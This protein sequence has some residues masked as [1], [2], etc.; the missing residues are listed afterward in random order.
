MTKRKKIIIG[1]AGT[2]VILLVA[3]FLLLPTLINLDLLREKILAK[4]SETE[5]VDIDFEKLELDFFPRPY[6]AVRQATVSIPGKAEGTLESLTVYPQILPLLR[7]KFRVSELV[8]AAPDFKV[9]LPER[10]KKEKEEE[11][12]SP[13]PWKALKEKVTS[14]LGHLTLKAAGL[15]VMVRNGRLELLD[16][17]K[18]VLKLEDIGASVSIPLGE[19]EADITCS[20]TCC[21]KVSIQTQIDMDDLE[22][23]GQIHLKHFNPNMIPAELIPPKV[24]RFGDSRVNL[25]VE[26]ETEGL[27]FIKGAVKGSTPELTV[28]NKN[29]K[30]VI[31]GKS[32]KGTFYTDAEK[33]TISVSELNLDHPRLK[34]KGEFL[35]DRNRAKPELT[36]NIQ[37]KD[38]DVSSG[39]IA[40]LVFAERHSVCR[41]ICEVLQGGTVQQVTFGIRGSTKQ[42]WKKSENITLKGNMVDGEITVPVGDHLY[43]KNVMGEVDI[44]N[45]MLEGKNLQGRLGKSK[46]SKG[47][48][49]LGLQG[50]K[51]KTAAFHLDVALEADLAELPPVLKR[52]VRNET[53]VKHVD[54]VK[55][56]KGNATGRLVMGDSISS[57]KTHVI[58]SKSNMVARYGPTPY[59]VQ[60]K[61]G[62]LLQKDKRVDLKNV[63]GQ[64]GKSSFSGL[65]A[66]I[67]G[68]KELHL[69]AKAGN[70]SIVLDEIYPWLMSYDEVAKGMGRFKSLSGTVLP[71][72]LS[73]KGPVLKPKKW[74][75]RVAGDVKNLG[76]DTSL[77]PQPITVTQGTF[78]ATPERISVK[79]ARTDALGASLQISGFVEDYQKGVNKTE[80]DFAGTV[81]PESVEWVSKLVHLPRE[82]YLKSTVSISKARLV[83]EKGV[84]TS[85]SGK[86]AAEQGTTISMDVIHNP[87]E[88]L[89]RELL[90]KDQQ[91]DAAITFNLKDKEFGL[92]FSGEL[93]KP[94]LDRCLLVNECLEGWIKGDFQ[95]QV[96]L[97]QPARTVANGNLQ[98]EN[99]ALPWILKVPTTIQDV[100]LDAEQNNFRVTSALVILGDDR[101][102]LDG[103]VTAKEEG[104]VFDMNLAAQEVEWHHV[105]NLLGIEGE[106]GE[107]GKEE[108]PRQPKDSWDLPLRGVLR[109]KTSGFVYEGFKFTPFH[110]DISIDR[111]RVSVDVREANL[112]GDISTLGTLSVTP[113]ELQFNF[114][115]AAKEQELDSILTCAMDKKGFMVGKYNFDGEVKAKAKPAD[116]ARSLQGDLTFSAGK[117]VIYRSNV[118]VKIFGFLNITDIFE[119]EVPNLS[120]EGFAYNYITAIGTL[121]GDKLVVKEAIVDGYSMKMFAQGDVDLTS[122]TLDLTVAVAP[123]K[124]IDFIVSKIPLVNHIL[125]G[126]LISIPMKVKGPWGDPVVKGISASGV[127]SGFLGIIERTVELPVKLIEPLAPT[128]KKK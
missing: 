54:L 49:K 128:D 57:I 81:E 91:S 113:K 58:I 17:E 28:Y 98:A 86:M 115:P 48:F 100:S 23:T 117:G 63:A 112:C 124:T 67:D 72:A 31:K 7:G 13:S 9:T 97:G 110:A 74:K 12:K 69:D 118:L 29:N 3:L 108:E 10:E 84:G 73:L 85:F 6:G 1:I 88:L 25:N 125:G 2:L 93:H 56:I 107:G 106:E 47:T 42:D 116:A 40:A 64:L 126:T 55:D 111:N 20:S 82:L 102:T 14:T 38:A 90:I 89:V 46:A 101:I 5:G 105:R 83:W 24:P 127:G 122:K 92:S 35:W 45:G 103:E 121:Q 76:V 8:I 19:L 99:I 79:E 80:I 51:E 44:A 114:K 41:K 60:I 37:G 18:S 104:F 39:R 61:Q 21:E 43:L 27:E 70:S 34:A 36:M 77:F 59:P 109:L 120:R 71:S 50:L 4:I 87:E 62:E 52:V 30:I 96:A 26:F 11:K 53:F 22:A 75:F 119:G 32:L 65:S 95:T 68:D 123:L 78:E 16:K 33:T 15:D 94:T 66:R